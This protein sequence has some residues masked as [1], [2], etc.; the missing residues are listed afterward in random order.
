MMI[1]SAQLLDDNI[2]IS[3]LYLGRPIFP[4]HFLPQGMKKLRKIWRSPLMPVSLALCFCQMVVKQM[5]TYHF[6]LV[7]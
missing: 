4:V 7:A 1:C 3:T 2:L 6:F 5:V